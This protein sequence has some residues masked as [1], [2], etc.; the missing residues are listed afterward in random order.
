MEAKGLGVGEVLLIVG[1]AVVATVGGVVWA[2]AWLATEATGGAFHAGLQ[3]AVLAATRLPGHLSE[4]A[5]AW[6]ST[7]VGEIPG[8]LEYWGA[9]GAVLMMTLAVAAVA[10]RI[11]GGSRVGSERRRP[12]GVDARARFATR[13]DLAPL[14]VRGRHPGRFV[15]G[16]CHGLLVA[17]EDG[18]RRG[19]RTGDRGAVALVGPSRCG[20]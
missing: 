7:S 11:W 9:T 6:T 16:R 20:K 13:R 18:T 19:R 12:L 4:P 1:A 3:D 2:G 5:S 15:L 17:T 10:F 14:R 8:P